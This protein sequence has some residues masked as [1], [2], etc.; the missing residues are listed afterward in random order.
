V[1]DVYRKKEV[2]ESE[3]TNIG[4]HVVIYLVQLFK[5]YNQHVTCLPSLQA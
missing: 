1:T 3:A 5:K 4:Y 2:K